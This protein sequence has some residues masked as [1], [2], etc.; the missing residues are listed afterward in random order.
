MKKIIILIFAFFLLIPFINL[1]ADSLEFNKEEVVVNKSSYQVVKRTNQDKLAFGIEHIRDEALSK[2]ESL[3]TPA[4]NLDP[5]VTNVLNIPSNKIVKVI[6]WTFQSNTRWVRQTVKY[7]AKDYEK[8]NPGWIVLAAVNGDFFDIDSKQLFAGSTTSAAMNQ[9]DLVRAEGHSTVSHKQIGFTNDGTTNSVIG[10]ALYQITDQHYL[11]IYNNKDESIIEVA[12]D[13][14]NEEPT[15]DEV[16]LYFGYPYWNEDKTIRLEYKPT[17]PNTNS[18]TV[19]LAERCYPDDK[20]HIFAKG[21]ISNINESMQLNIGQFSIVTNNEDII[22]KLQLDTKIRIQQNVIGDYENCT[23]ITGGGVTLLKNGE[24]PENLEAITDYRHPRTYIG[25][26]KDGTISLFTSDGR[27]QANGM[28]GVGYE[29]MTAIL[30]YYGCVDGYNVDGGGS[31]TMIIRNEFGDFDVVNS[32][33]DGSERT[34]SNAILV[35]APGAK[36]FIDK[37]NDVEASFN[38][39]SSIKDMIMYN[40][41]ACLVDKNGNEK[42]MDIQDGS[43][44][45]DNLNPQSEYDVYIKY[46]LK[47]NETVIDGASAKVH[48]KTGDPKPIVNI[49]N[50]EKVDGGYR[51]NYNVSDPYNTILYLTIDFEGDFVETS[52][53]VGSTFIADSQVTEPNFVLS[54]RYDLRS[55]PNDTLYMDINIPLKVIDNTPSE[56]TP[57][58]KKCGKKSAELF[59]SLLSILT[60]FAVILKKK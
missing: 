34:V 33:S 19:K 48:F 10:D 55:D 35:V 44:K 27:Q 28:T 17:I 21:L 51:I 56:E 43:F 2:S 53:L 57:S 24:V 32:P 16:S 60:I 42:E 23:D 54:M 3:L 40:T 12:I 26:K 29:E 22:S 36:T 4:I 46:Q 45:F 9:G 8:N 50:Y 15:G 20:D 31:T 6:N 18:F 37:V 59:I 13:K 5:Q 41:K 1:K 7:L 30:K 39:T 14:F 47:Y 58:K 49:V 11:T 52:G 38:Y 25:K